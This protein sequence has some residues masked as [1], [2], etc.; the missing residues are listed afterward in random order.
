MNSDYLKTVIN[1]QMSNPFAV[2]DSTAGTAFLV[3]EANAA[4]P[5]TFIALGGAAAK[6][7]VLS[8]TGG[9][10]K[11]SLEDRLGMLEFFGTGLQGYQGI[12]TSGATQ[13]TVFSQAPDGGKI[14]TVMPMVTD[15]P[16]VIA[17]TNPGSI[18]LGHA[19]RVADIMR[20]YDNGRFA[21]APYDNFLN[22]RYHGVML[23]QKGSDLV[24]DWDGD[25]GMYLSAIDMWQNYSKYNVVTV[26][27]NGG[28]VTRAEVKAA[29]L[30]N[31][32]V[33]VIEGSGRAAD[34]V[35]VPAIRA[36]SKS[37][38]FLHAFGKP[39]AN[40]KIVSRGDCQGLRD[41]C[42]EAGIL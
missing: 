6:K 28:D 14:E 12:V 33:V 27:W 5:A 8:V 40:V 32:T 38:A 25:V 30:R 39:D 23:V 10:S 2:L 29:A 7:A 17:A 4:V 35:L 41:V 15:I 9:C 34:D 42:T 21:I 36:G 19:P 31:H 1:S 16:G 11:Q 18:A 3:A 20:F 26:A 22:C 13:N 37:E 24:L